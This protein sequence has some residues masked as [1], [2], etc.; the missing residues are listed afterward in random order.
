MNVWFTAV[1]VNVPARTPT[2]C[3]GNAPAVILCS[4]EVLSVL[5]AWVSLLAALI[6]PIPLEEQFF[7][8]RST[9]WPNSIRHDPENHTQAKGS[10]GTVAPSVLGSQRN[11]RTLRVAMPDEPSNEVDL[12]AF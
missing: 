1:V 2:S 6:F 3:S 10:S 5:A 9:L 11:P 4:P 7:Q 8:S 12:S